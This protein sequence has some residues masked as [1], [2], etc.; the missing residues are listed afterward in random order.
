[1]QN[2]PSDWTKGFTQGR[3]RIACDG[4]EIPVYHQVYGWTL[5]VW[6][7][8]DRKHLVYCYKTDTF[9]ND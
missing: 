2:I 5:L 9:L 1:M 4:K 3:Y 6:D 7:S 8:K